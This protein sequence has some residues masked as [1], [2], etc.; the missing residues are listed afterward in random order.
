MASE[1]RESPPDSIH[2]ATHH[3]PVIPHVEAFATDHPN[4]DQQE[5]PEAV[6]AESGGRGVRCQ[7]QGRQAGRRRL[8]EIDVAAALVAEVPV[9]A[10]PQDDQQADAVAK[11][12]VCG[13][14]GV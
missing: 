9:A 5:Q 2:I 8:A 7:L 13:R 6:V 4:N 1:Y 14:S 10:E 3:T 11:V 12:R